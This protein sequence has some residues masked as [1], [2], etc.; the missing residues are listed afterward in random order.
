MKNGIV[1]ILTIAALTFAGIT[2]DLI[3]LPENCRTLANEL[4]ST[5]KVTGLEL[6]GTPGLLLLKSLVIQRAQTGTTVKQKA[7]SL[8]TLLLSTYRKQL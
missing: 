6:N 8:V 1:D 4:V 5:C 2:S 7:G 3:I